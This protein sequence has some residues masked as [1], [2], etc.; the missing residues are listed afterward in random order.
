[1][2]I[3]S[4]CGSFVF[5]SMLQYWTICTVECRV[6]IFYS[7]SLSSLP[8]LRIGDAISAVEREWSGSR[9]YPP[10]S[11]PPS[12]ST[13]SLPLSPTHTHR[14]TTQRDSSTGY[15]HVVLVSVSYLS[16]RKD[17]ESPNMSTS[18]TH[19]L[20]H[21]MSNSLTQSYIKAEIRITLLQPYYYTHSNIRPLMHYN[22]YNIHAHS[23]VTMA[24]MYTSIR[25]ECAQIG[26]F[27]RGSCEST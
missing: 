7:L 15:I 13:P 11:L 18:S 22:T 4:V 3:S 14:V 23:L 2:I 5:V 19:S 21:I 9:D 12:L 17:S 25:L 20:R 8:N 10:P 26:T 1:M 27:G 6:S 24:T 16:I